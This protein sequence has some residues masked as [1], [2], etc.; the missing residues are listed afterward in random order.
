MSTFL[1]VFTKHVAILD[2]RPT[3]L[4]PNG[5]MIDNLI[6]W[7]TDGVAAIQTA[8]LV[9]T[10]DVASNVFCGY[11]AVDAP[12]NPIPLAVSA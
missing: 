12:V 3:Y 4:N 8:T 5:D 2:D 10:S 9:A 11:P 6:L 7:H 1:N